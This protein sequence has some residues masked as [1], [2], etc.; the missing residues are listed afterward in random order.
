MK[1]SDRMKIYEKTFYHSALKRMPLIIR[2]DGRA[3]HSFTKQFKRPFDEHFMNAM[4]LAAENTAKEMQGF[5]V[6]YIQSDEVTFALTDYDQLETQGWFNYELPKIISL[7]SSIMTAN[8]NRIINSDR[9]ATFDSRAFT[10][11]KEEVVNVFLWRAKDWQ[12]NSIQ[13]YCQ[14]FFSQKQLHK[15]KQAD[16]H[17]MLYSIGKNWT[18]D[19]DNRQ[20]NG[21]FIIRREGTI[22]TK[23]SILPNFQ[24][25]SDAIGDLF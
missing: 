16:M 11:P 10:V 15:K 22:V 3:F 20:K 24:S 7:S 25:I 19:L 6:A 12:R 17:E 14:S 21:T 1:L 2:I 8:F 23:S 13:M 18:N 9:I 4:V 5:K